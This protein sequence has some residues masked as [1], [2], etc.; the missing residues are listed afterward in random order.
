MNLWDIVNYAIAI[1]PF[2]TNEEILQFCKEIQEML[3]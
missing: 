1:S 3:S 2:A